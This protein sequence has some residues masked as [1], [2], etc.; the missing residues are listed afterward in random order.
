MNEESRNVLMSSDRMDWGTPQKFFDELNEEFNF[1]LDPASDGKNNKCAK[2]YTKEQNGLLQ[3]W[4]DESVFVNPP[5]GR[6]VKAW[7]KKCSEEQGKAKVV[8]ALLA[9]RTDT[10]MFHEYIWDREIQL[11]YQGIEVRFL[12]G[13]LK[14]EGAK[15]VAPFLSIVV[16]WRKV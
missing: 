8:V 7:V 12:K 5:Y 6:E 2:F 10:I 4:E 9:S 13:R 16:I 3:S 14:F 11:P 1:T 15:D